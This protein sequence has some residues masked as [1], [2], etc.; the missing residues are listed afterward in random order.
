MFRFSVYIVHIVIHTMHRFFSHI[1]F[2]TFIAL[3]TGFALASV[4]HHDGT[5]HS[6]ELI[7]EFADFECSMCDGTVKIDH[8]TLSI[9]S[10]DLIPISTVSDGMV[11]TAKLPFERL[12][13]DRAP[14]SRA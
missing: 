5:I 1:K 11:L 6:A 8:V 4:H 2:L 3:L 9:S 7:I 10:L 13:K 14:P 12:I